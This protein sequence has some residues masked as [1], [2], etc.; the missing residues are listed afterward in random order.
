MTGVKKPMSAHSSVITAAMIGDYGA[1][2]ADDGAVQLWITA[3][4]KRDHGGQEGDYGAL[5]L[6]FTAVSIDHECAVV[7]D[8]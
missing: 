1:L 7:A 6:A 4:V 3:H 8:A 5:F 2:I